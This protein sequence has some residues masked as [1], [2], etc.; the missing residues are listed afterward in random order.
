[1]EAARTDGPELALASWGLPLNCPEDIGL[2]SSPSCGKKP[3]FTARC[4]WLKIGFNLLKLW[5]SKDCYQDPFLQMVVL[6]IEDQE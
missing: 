5:L 4:P 3:S 1:M 6:P 2:P